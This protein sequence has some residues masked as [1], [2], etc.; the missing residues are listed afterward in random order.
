MLRAT[1]GNLRLKVDT[2]LDNPRDILA[3]L[4]RM[5][6]QPNPTEKKD[7]TTAWNQAK[8]H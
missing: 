3:E 4:I 6:G 1:G 8:I 7:A 2:A 5:Y